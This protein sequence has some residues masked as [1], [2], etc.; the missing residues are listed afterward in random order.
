LTASASSHRRRDA[1]TAAKCRT[2]RVIQQDIES[3]AWAE[4]LSHHGFNGWRGDR[5]AATLPHRRQSGDEDDPL[6]FG[7][8][9]VQGRYWL[10]RRQGF[11][12]RQV[13]GLPL[14][15]SRAPICPSASDPGPAYFLIELAKTS[16]ALRAKNRPRD[17]THGPMIGPHEHLASFLALAPLVARPNGSES[18]GRLKRAQHARLRK[19][20]S[21]CESRRG[22]Q[23]S[24]RIFR[25]E[26]G[27]DD[28][29]VRPDAMALVGRIRRQDA[30][31][32]LRQRS[33]VALS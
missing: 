30:F 14:L 11:P 25:S 5:S 4:Q 8:Q 2:T 31:E 3:Q 33:Y 18:C 20:G 13:Q 23:N 24:P 22:P 9:I 1:S 16:R 6:R 12:A 19:C 26:I 32:D 7:H 15:R 28:E 17:G 10:P 21:W 29:V 27:M